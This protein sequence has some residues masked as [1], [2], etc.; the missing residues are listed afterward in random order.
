MR[1]C[2]GGRGHWRG[3]GTGAARPLRNGRGTPCTRMETHFVI[4]DPDA[5][6]VVE[7]DRLDSISVDEGTFL[8]RQVANRIV[9][10]LPRNHRMA[11][12][13]ARVAEE[14]DWILFGAPDRRRRAFDTILA[15]P[16][17]SRFH[18]QPCRLG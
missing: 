12:L 4:A 11:R 14:P 13:H 7:R 17:S 18:R 8:Y 1:R 16:Q 5:I 9:A 6:A 2:D 3:R 15:S 10:T